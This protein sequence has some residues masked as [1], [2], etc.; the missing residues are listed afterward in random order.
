MHGVCQARRYSEATAWQ[1]SGKKR[2]CIAINS[3]FT[4]IDFETETLQLNC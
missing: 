2:A 1:T 4:V 3:R